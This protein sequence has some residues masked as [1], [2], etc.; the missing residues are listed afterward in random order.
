MK[1]VGAFDS[2]KKTPVKDVKIK[3]KW[4]PSRG[5]CEVSYNSPS[6]DEVAVSQTPSLE[7][8]RKV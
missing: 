7:S 6:L 3:Y 1:V 5:K 4:D 8:N 2:E